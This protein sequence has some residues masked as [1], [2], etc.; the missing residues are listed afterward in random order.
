M[1]LAVLGTWE[2]ESISLY[3]L[4]FFHPLLWPQSPQG[5]ISRSENS[6]SLVDLAIKLRGGWVHTEE[7]I[8][9]SALRFLVVERS[10]S[11]PKA[12]GMRLKLCLK[13]L[14]WEE[15][16][17]KIKEDQSEPWGGSGSARDWMILTAVGRSSQRQVQ[18]VLSAFSYCGIIGFLS[19]IVT[20]W[21]S[22][23]LLA[24]LF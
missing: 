7:Q 19:E 24:F 4:F 10:T 1:S 6:R 14:V 15:R 9:G 21:A 2:A 12:L 13:R 16:S 18:Y 22:L 5:Q 17:K 8:W 3:A 20:Y 23:L 11:L